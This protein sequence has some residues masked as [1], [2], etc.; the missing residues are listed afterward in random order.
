[1]S[2][3]DEILSML[4]DSRS[5]L[6]SAIRGLPEDKMTVPL[7][8]EWSAKDIM[9]HITSWDEF[10]ASDLRRIARG[11]LPC[12][13]AFREAD[14]D[15]WNAFLIRPRKLFPLPQI[16]AEFEEARAEMVAALKDLPEG[17]LAEGQMVRNIFVIMANHEKDHARQ[18]R[19]WRQQEGL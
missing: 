11:R 1:V 13:A 7:A 16:Q 9:G 5:E 6:A 12:L 4:E 14:V 19:E 8:D 3:R 2:D 10:T 15:S 18:V 17:L